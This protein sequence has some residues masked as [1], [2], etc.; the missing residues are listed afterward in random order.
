MPKTPAATAAAAMSFPGTVKRALSPADSSS[1]PVSVDTATGRFGVVLITATP[2]RRTIDDPRNP[3]QQIVVDEV[4]VPEGVDL[5]R[6]QGM[7]LIDGHRTGDGL[8]AILGKID[9]VR[10]EDG[11]IVGDAMFA[12]DHEH[13]LKDV[14]RGFYRQG[15]IAADILEVE[16]V[17][18]V[19]DVPLVLITRSLATDYSLV[20]VGADP[21]CIIRSADTPSPPKVT[22]RAADPATTP[23]QEKTMDLEEIV[24]AAEAALAAADAAVAAEGTANEL[25][26]RVR[27]LRTARAAEEEAA[28]TD[29]EKPAVERAADDEAETPEDKAE[30][31]TIRTVARSYGLGKL[32]DD[33]LVLRA[34]PADLRKA[35]RGAIAERG[36]ASTDTQVIVKSAVQRAAEPLN[37]AAIYAARNKL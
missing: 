26:E 3:G 36:A 28:K 7:P 4:I 14:E 37:T 21:N 29:E 18:R 6:A 35:V 10:L 11:K 34:K 5:S 17:D 25:V 9:N 20:A 31:E 22:V 19:D 13:L 30:T 27:S 2:V 32:V 12:S 24:A 16:W 15:S 8:K 1:I 23:T 33:M